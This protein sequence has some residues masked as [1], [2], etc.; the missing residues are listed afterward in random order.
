MRSM[1]LWVV[2]LRCLTLGQG[3]SYL[4]LPASRNLLANLVPQQIRDRRKSLQRHHGGIRPV[5]F[6]SLLFCKITSHGFRILGLSKSAGQLLP[7]FL[8]FGAVQ[9]SIRSKKAKGFYECATECQGRIRRLPSLP[10]VWRS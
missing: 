8:E 6:F 9:G 5:V 7:R 3:H 4:A 10:A 1:L 2:C